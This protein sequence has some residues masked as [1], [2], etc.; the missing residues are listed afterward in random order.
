MKKILVA[1]TVLAGAMTMNAA[2]AAPA[3]SAEVGTTGFGLHLTLPVAAKINTRIGFNAFSYD[4]SDTVDDVDY[5]AKLKLN[6]ID[7]LLDYYPFSSG[8]RLTGGIV[9]NNS[10]IDITARSNSNQTYTFNDRVYIANQV[11]EVDGRIDFRKTAPYLGFGWGNALGT[12]RGWSFTSDFGVLFQGSPRTSLTSRNCT[13]D[14][15]LCS[16]LATDLAEENR[17][18]QDDADSFRF[19]PVVRVGVSYRF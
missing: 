11:G 14:A 8:M 7:A 13:I 19:Y 17:Q 18:L 10:K 6:T 4:T 15:T 9:Y 12:Q 16:Q 2:S 5:D 1:A 3:I